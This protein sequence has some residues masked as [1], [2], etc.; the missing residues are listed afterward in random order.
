V[1]YLWGKWGMHPPLFQEPVFGFIQEVGSMG[2]GV[3]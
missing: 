1:E 3:A 2:L